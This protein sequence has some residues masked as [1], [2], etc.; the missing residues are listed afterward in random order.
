[1]P[2]KTWIFQLFTVE[3]SL[4][5]VCLC[6]RWNAR[7]DWYKIQHI[8]KL[9]ITLPIVWR[10]HLTHNTYF[11]RCENLIHAVHEFG[12]G[13]KTYI[14]IKEVEISPTML[15]ICRHVG[16]L[17]QKAFC[18]APFFFFFLFGPPCNSETPTYSL[19]CKEE[20]PYS[21][22]QNTRK[23]GVCLSW[24]KCVATATENPKTALHSGLYPVR[25]PH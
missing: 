13:T 16:E 25:N 10:D 19:V 9:K 23:R 22:F 11:V 20:N 15:T 14:G 1:M 24:L 18:Y 6:P 5:C 8:S 12:W 2:P 21:L 3:L 7:A 17:G 4:N